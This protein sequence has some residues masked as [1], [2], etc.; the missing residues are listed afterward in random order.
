MT[1]TL[2]FFIYSFFFVVMAAHWGMTLNSYLSNR[3]P[4]ARI[5]LQFLS[6]WLL[7]NLFLFALITFPFPHL[8]TLSNR[9]V[10]Y[11]M[12]IRSAVTVGF[13]LSAFHCFWNRFE[14]PLGVGLRRFFWVYALS[15]PFVVTAAIVWSLFCPERLNTILK[16][17]TAAQ[18]F[19]SVGLILLIMIPPALVLARKKNKARRIEAAVI[20]GSLALFFPIYSA[21]PILRVFKA[22]GM[23][24]SF[25]LAFAFLWSAAGILLSVRNSS[26]KREETRTD[27][28]TLAKRYGWTDREHEIADRLSYGLSNKEI[29]HALG[30]SE[31][32]VKAHL[33]SLYQ[34]AGVRSRFECMNLF[35]RNVP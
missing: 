31:A 7:N 17:A 22:K 29:A 23:P 6:F 8:A 35:Y 9:L 33:T 20:L 4:K 24:F 2:I 26:R 18:E 11:F 15:Y 3:A 30:I 12:L 21:M 16:I 10:L 19:L 32:T 14:I 13:L 5:Y 34:K 28:A 27:F 1:Y 25:E